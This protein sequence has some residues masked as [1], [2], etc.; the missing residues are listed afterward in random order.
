MTHCTIAGKCSENLDWTHSGGEFC[1]SLAQS[2]VTRL[3]PTNR[4]PRVP[5]SSCGL[6]PRLPRR[7][8]GRV[9]RALQRRCG[10][11]LAYHLD[12]GRLRYAHV[13]PPTSPTIVLLSVA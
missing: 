7:W 8:Q 13:M 6:L 10:H 12:D 5:A 3:P 4:P 2:A 1:D 11:I 9:G